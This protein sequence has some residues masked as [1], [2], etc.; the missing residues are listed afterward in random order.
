VREHSATQD[1]P[2][3]S[4]ESSSSSSSSSSDSE[5]ESEENNSRHRSKGRNRQKLHAK[6]GDKHQKRHSRSSSSDSS[7]IKPKPPKDYDGAADARSF[8]RFV[9]EGTDYVIA[10]KVSHQ[11]RV[12]VLSYHLKGKVMIFIHKKS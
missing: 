5:S 10:G 6:K 7:K 3:L 4:S 12:F 1:G 8:H 11:R 2:V 9:M